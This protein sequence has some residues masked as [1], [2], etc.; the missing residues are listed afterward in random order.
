MVIGLLNDPVWLTAISLGLAALLGSA[1]WH[2][3]HHRFEFTA[4]L[5][6]YAVLAP[7]LIRPVSLLLPWLEIFAAVGLLMAAQQPFVALFAATLLLS[8]AAIM[9]LSLIQGRLIAD[10]G[11]HLGAQPQ[12]VSWSLAWRNLFL[13]LLSLNLLLPSNSRT[14]AVLDWLLIA[15]VLFCGSLFYLLINRL[16]ANQNTARELSL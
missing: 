7:R 15:C 11:C 2:K 14:L 8:Y 10:C 13:V 1:G 5:Q 9:A 6:G 16:I 3:L 4:A 12:A